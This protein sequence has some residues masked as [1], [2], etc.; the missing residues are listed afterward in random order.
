VQTSAAAIW[1]GRL[2]ARAAIR[3]TLLFLASDD[4]I[5]NW[6]AAFGQQLT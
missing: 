6:I 4:E 1:C 2:G 3:R 5:G